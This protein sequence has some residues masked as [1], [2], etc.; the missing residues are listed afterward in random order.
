MYWAPCDH[1]LR[2]LK[3]EVAPLKC[4]DLAHSEPQ[5]HGDDHHGLEWLIEAVARLLELVW[6]QNRLL[7][8]SLGRATFYLD[9]T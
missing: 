5:A 9:E 1:Q 7:P 2:T 8:T 6:C 3:I 4:E